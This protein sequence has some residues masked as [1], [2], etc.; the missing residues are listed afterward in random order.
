[1][2]ILRMFIGMVGAI[3][4]F[5][6]LVSVWGTWVGNESTTGPWVLSIVG[7]VM[8]LQGLPVI[9]ASEQEERRKFYRK[10]LKGEKD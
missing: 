4:C 7:A 2:N 3:L 10:L 8:W 6:G 1:M 9:W 5:I